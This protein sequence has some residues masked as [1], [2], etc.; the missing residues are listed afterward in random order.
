MAGVSRCPAGVTK[1]PWAFS[2]TRP[3]Q[4]S[5]FSANRLKADGAFRGMTA[6]LPG[7][8]R[9]GPMP[10]PPAPIENRSPSPVPKPGRWQVMQAMSLLPDR[11]LSK[12][13]AWPSRE[14]SGR[15]AAGRSSGPMPRP[16]A[17]VRTSAARPAVGES[18]NEGPAGAAESFS[19]QAPSNAADAV[20]ATSR[21]LGI[22]ASIFD[23]EGDSWPDYPRE[24]LNS[25]S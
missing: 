10:T 13:S 20:K 12:A 6:V 22:R 11:T 3:S 19:P 15:T 9:A 25:I 23:S 4:N 5:S 18:E 14:S 21:F 8:V 16:A 7:W 17:R 1:P 24:C 2:A